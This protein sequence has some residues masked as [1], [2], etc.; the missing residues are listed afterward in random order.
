MRALILHRIEAMR[1]AADGM[2][3]PVSCAFSAAEQRGID[4]KRDDFCFDSMPA[5]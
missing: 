3:E 5:R 1:R 2:E 4:A